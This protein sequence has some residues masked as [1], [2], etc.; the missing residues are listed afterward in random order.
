MDSITVLVDL[1]LDATVLTNDTNYCEN[2][3]ILSPN[4]LNSGGFWI[5]QSVD[6]LSGLISNNLSPSFYS[7]QYIT[8]NSNNCSD[9]GSYQIQIIPNNDATILNP[10]IICDNL[11]AITLN[12]SQSG[13]HQHLMSQS[14][15]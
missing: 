15:S 11:D 2:A 10:G 1:P 9:T 14:L 6:S 3:S 12:T 13:L 4:V 5:G 7:Y 8:V